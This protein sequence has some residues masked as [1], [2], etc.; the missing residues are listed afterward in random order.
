MIMM[1]VNDRE[2]NCKVKHTLA[3]RQKVSV[4]VSDHQS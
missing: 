2:T 1:L 3:L 4:A